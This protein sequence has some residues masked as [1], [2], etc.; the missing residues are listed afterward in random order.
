MQLDGS[1]AIAMEEQIC[2][3]HIELSINLYHTPISHAILSR[4][5]HCQQKGSCV[6]V[7]L[8]LK[9][10][11]PSHDLHEIPWGRPIVSKCE[12]SIVLEC[13]QSLQTSSILPKQV[14]TEPVRLNYYGQGWCTKCAVAEYPRCLSFDPHFLRPMNNSLDTRIRKSVASYVLVRGKLLFRCEDPKHDLH[15]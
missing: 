2:S 4:S 6:H 3:R 12:Y 14:K 11:H 5:C 8:R 15:H 1:I 10:M 9:Y 13:H 7:S